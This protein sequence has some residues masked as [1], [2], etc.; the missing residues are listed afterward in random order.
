MAVS[1]RIARNLIVFPSSLELRKILLKTGLSDTSDM[2]KC[3]RGVLKHNFN[4]MD[5]RIVFVLFIFALDYD[6]FN[7]CLFPMKFMCD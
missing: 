2:M 7:S 1:Q 5:N 6:K 3:H 4:I